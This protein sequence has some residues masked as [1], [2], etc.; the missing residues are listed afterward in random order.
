MGGV[1]KRKADPKD[2]RVCR[3][4]VVAETDAEARDMVF[5]SKSTLNY[6]FS[7]LW[8]ALSIANYTIVLKA[9]PALWRAST[10]TWRL[11][12]R[13]PRSSFPEAKRLLR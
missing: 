3:N 9:N 4:I 12:P 10:Q 2:W 5:D 11:Q 6:Y 7:Y 13:G 1:A 8:K